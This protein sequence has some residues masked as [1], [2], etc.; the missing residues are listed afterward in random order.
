MIWQPLSASQPSSG[1]TPAAAA[2]K[3]DQPVTKPSPSSVA[4]YLQE[5]LPNQRAT[6]SGDM[7]EAKNML[8]CGADAPA[9]KAV[10]ERGSS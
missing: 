3:L 5:G 1:S 9:Y 4:D 2:M 8:A 6:D 7:V 10:R